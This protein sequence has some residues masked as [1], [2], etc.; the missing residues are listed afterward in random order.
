MN[1]SFFVSLQGEA[2]FNLFITNPE[3]MLSRQS[4]ETKDSRRNS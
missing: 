1:G 3:K 4:W 2:A